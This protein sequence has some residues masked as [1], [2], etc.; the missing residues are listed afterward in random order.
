LDRRVSLLLGRLERSKPSHVAHVTAH[1]DF[2][3]GQLIES[4][5]LALVDLD[6]CCATSPADDLGWYA[7]HA[8]R[9]DERDPEAVDEVVEALAQGYGSRPT[10]LPWYVSASLLARAPFPFRRQAPDWPE[11]VERL[12]IAAELARPGR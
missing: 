4:D 6:D 11:R 8:A 10:E 5:G 7:A 1:G 12:L 9:G 2:E 3:P